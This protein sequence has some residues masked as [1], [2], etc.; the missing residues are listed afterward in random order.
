MSDKENMLLDMSIRNL[1]AK[2]AIG[3]LDAVR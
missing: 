3:L 2:E 1:L